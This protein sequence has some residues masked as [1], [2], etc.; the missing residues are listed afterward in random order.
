MLARLVDV[1]RDAAAGAPPDGWRRWEGVEG[2]LSMAVLEMEGSEGRAL[3]DEAGL[4]ENLLF[5]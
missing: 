1:G 2:V 5:S 3:L 4:A